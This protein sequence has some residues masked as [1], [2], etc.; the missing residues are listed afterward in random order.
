MFIV[1][2]GCGYTGVQCKMTSYLFEFFHSKL[3]GE[4]Y[5][6]QKWQDIKESATIKAGQI[7]IKLF[8]DISRQQ[9][10]TIKYRGSR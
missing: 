2:Y 9:R 4:I 3:L 5:Y 1:K 6:E 8:A 10:I 7:L